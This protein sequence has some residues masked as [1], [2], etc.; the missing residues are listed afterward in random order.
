MSANDPKDDKS[1]PFNNPFAALSGKRG[2]LPA[3][4]APR[5]KPAPKGPPKAVVR[6]ERKGRGGKEV[7]VVEQLSLGTRELDKWLKELKQSLGCGGAVEDNSLVIQ[8]DQRERVRDWL[9]RRGVA[10]V[11]VG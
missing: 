2:E 6:L 7:T 8:G 10:K 3:G 5:E 4:P 11:S 9:T 1:A